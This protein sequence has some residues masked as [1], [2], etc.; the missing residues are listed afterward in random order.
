MTELSYSP[1]TSK[2]VAGFSK[3]DTVIANVIDYV[4]MDGQQS[5]RTIQTLFISKEM[6]CQ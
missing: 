4:Y 5:S 3:K 2:E 1:V 6:N